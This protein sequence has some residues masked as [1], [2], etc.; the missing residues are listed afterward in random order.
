MRVVT[1]VLEILQFARTKLQVT[2]CV[3]ATRKRVGQG[4][5]KCSNSACTYWEVSPLF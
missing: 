3:I 1:V 5:S 4:E 2:I